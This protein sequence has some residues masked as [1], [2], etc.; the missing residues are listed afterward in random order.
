MAKVAEYLV[1]TF[2]GEVCRTKINS[3]D[4]Q[5][6]IGASGELMGVMDTPTQTDTVAKVT[7]FDLKKN[8]TENRPEQLIHEIAIPFVKNKL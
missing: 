3:F 1:K 5:L 8:F 4:I 6:C 2:E 7:V